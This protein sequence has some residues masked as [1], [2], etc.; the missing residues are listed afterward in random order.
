MSQEDD[1]EPDDDTT[2][3]AN[4][5]EP[6]G[7][8]DNDG[9]DDGGDGSSD[10][11]L[12]DA[13][14]REQARNA[15]LEKRVAELED[16]LDAARGDESEELQKLREDIAD[17]KAENDRLAEESREG[18]LNRAVL[19][20]ANKHGLTRPDVALRLVDKANIEITDDGEVAGATAE[21]SRIEEEFSD[22]MPTLFGGQSGDND[23]EDDQTTS[24]SA[25][26]S[27]SG[28]SSD[29]SGSDD[30]KPESDED[31]GAKL[32]DRTEKERNKPI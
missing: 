24:T 1:N 29:R 21:I 23:G 8:P 4:D 19:E 9:T 13:L 15:K 18:R 27:G 11:P 22:S 17:L 28:K 31:I 6:K 2:K 14:S 30:Q 32:F 25:S 20:A 26:D 7:E 3:P 10:D 12:R 5:Q 16:E